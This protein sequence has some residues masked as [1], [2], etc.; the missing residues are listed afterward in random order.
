M[1]VS[2]LQE[3]ARCKELPALE[4]LRTLR[5][6]KLLG[7]VSD[8][9]KLIEKGRALKWLET[10]GFYVE[11]PSSSAGIMPWLATVLGLAGVQS[12]AD[13]QWSKRSTRLQVLQVVWDYVQPYSPSFGH[14][15]GKLMELELTDFRPT[16]TH[17]QFFFQQLTELTRLRRLCLDCGSHMGKITEWELPEDIN[18]L[19]DLQELRLTWAPITLLP[20]KFTLLINLQVVELEYC[21]RLTSLPQGFAVNQP[22]LL[23]LSFAGCASLQ[24]L[25]SSIGALPSLQLLN[26]RECLKLETLDGTIGS[27]IGTSG[28]M[29]EV[30]WPERPLPSL[31][32]LSLHYCTSLRK[33]PQSFRGLSKLQHLDLAG[34]R[35]LED[36]TGIITM[37]PNLKQVVLSYEADLPLQI[38]HLQQSPQ[39]GDG[40]VPQA[41]GSKVYYTP[42]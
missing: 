23:E 42:Q 39:P 10:P 12:G 34:T 36:R 20:P 7:G 27:S 28:E 29:V 35:Q 9:I 4:H 8:A 37:M 5:L 30:G 17:A 18:C 21:K 32:W 2:L 15:F 14:V 16:T 24:G 25:P 11:T 6:H 31:S 26:L 22:G 1:G 40:D 13:P 3:S 38:G 19:A 41:L 33:L